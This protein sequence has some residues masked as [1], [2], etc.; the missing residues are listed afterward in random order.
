MNLVFWTFRDN[1]L[2]AYQS[3]ILHNSKLIKAS[4]RL[5]SS[6]PPWVNEHKGLIIVVS[7][8][9]KMHLRLALTLW[10][11]FIYIMKSGGPNIEPWCTPVSITRVEDAVPSYSTYWR[12]CFRWF[13]NQSRGVSLMPWYLSFVKRMS[14]FKVSKA[15]DTSKKT[16]KGTFFWSISCR[17]LSVSSKA[18]SSVEWCLRN[19]YWLSKSKPWRER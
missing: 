14:W 9:Y 5:M 15:F 4:T 18:A 2:T 19:P 10:I 12:R 11:S 3:E 7:S 17:I 6:L 1:L 13:L 8:A 16:A